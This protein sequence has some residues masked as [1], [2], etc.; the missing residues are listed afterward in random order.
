MKVGPLGTKG[1]SGPGYHI[2]IGLPWPRRATFFTTFSS[3]LLKTLFFYCFS[4]EFCL[5][6][7]LIFDVFLCV[8]RSRSHLA[9]NLANPVFEQHYS[10]LRSKSRFDPFGKTSN[11][12]F[13]LF[14]FDTC[15]GIDFESSWDNFGIVLG[16]CL[17]HF[18]IVF[19]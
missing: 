2:L 5:D 14:F 1:S 15:F 11:F 19:G 16:S 8:S 10:V 17:H 6:S 7:H 4:M 18:G 9:R 12:V 13:F 3:D